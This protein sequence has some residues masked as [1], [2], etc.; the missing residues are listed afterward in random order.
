MK[1]ILHLTMSGAYGGA[2]NIIFSIIDNL[3]KDYDF[4]YICPK[5]SLENELKDRNINYI[6]FNPHNLKKLRHEI[7]KI[8]PDIIH[9][10]D[11]RA[12]FIA[13]L[14]FKKMIISSLHTRHP[15]IN[16]LGLKSLAYLVSSIKFKKVI[17]G[18]LEFKENLKIRKFLINKLEVILNTVS[19]SRVLKLSAD[20]QPKH[21]Y[22]ICFLGRLSDY[23]DPLK[24]IKIVD[25]VRKKMHKI[26]AVIIGDGEL[27]E[28]CE[29]LIKDLKL[30]NNIKLKGYLKNPYPLLK[31]CEILV[32]PSKHDGLALVTIE[33][34]I[35]SKP[36]VASKVGSLPE[37]V[38][39][40]GKLCD[41]LEEFA[42][43]IVSL[44]TQ[45]D[46]YTEKSLNSL[47]LSKKYTNEKVYF[48]R[49]SSIY[50]L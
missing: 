30:E 11:F 45:K 20:Y 49:I 25:G 12:S 32:V 31:N 1:K 46:I 13:S 26:N 29:N 43:E 21:S 3:K 38:K 42:E 14:V 22:D 27:K 34:M 28:E 41:S 4:Y 39:S 17:V 24:F 15:W 50:N 44:L 33:A 16:K 19:E 2:E 40:N 48:K 36:I 23:K 37:V 10:H 47:N 18:D 6:C 9:A 35:L 8:N 7:K 5:G